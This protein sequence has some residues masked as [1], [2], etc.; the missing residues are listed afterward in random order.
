MV[1]TVQTVRSDGSDGSFRWH[2]YGW[3]WSSWVGLAAGWSSWVG[4]YILLIN[5]VDKRL[6]WWVV[7]PGR[8]K[9][10]SSVSSCWF[11]GWAH[12]EVVGRNKMVIKMVNRLLV[13]HLELFEIDVD[14]NLFCYEKYLEKFV[15]NFWQWGSWYEAVFFKRGFLIFCKEVLILKIKKKDTIKFPFK[16]HFLFRKT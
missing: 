2:S 15:V 9:V 6:V 1:R 3:G 11:P 7:F 10:I 8:V 12:V 5:P 16:K 13:V 4:R 14:I